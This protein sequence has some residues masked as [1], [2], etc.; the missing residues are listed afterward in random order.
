LWLDLR[1]AWATYAAHVAALPVIPGPNELR[2]SP[3]P[4]AVIFDVFDQ[5]VSLAQ[6]YK[7]DNEDIIHCA[8]GALW[9]RIEI[10][11]GSKLEELF[12]R[13]TDQ[14]RGC[15]GKTWAEYEEEFKKK[16]GT[17]I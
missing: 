1:T 17:V 3:A 8:L 15:E 6:A 5:L 14:G 2:L 10:E 7:V 16:T 11:K 9:N 12:E 13:A 4:S